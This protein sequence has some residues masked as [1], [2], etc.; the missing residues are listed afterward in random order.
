MSTST[1]TPT[2]FFT[3]LTEPTD[4]ANPS[5]LPSDFDATMAMILAKACGHTYTQ[6]AQ[7]SPLTEAQY[8]NLNTDGTHYTFSCVATFTASEALGPSDLGTPQP[9]PGAG[10][11]DTVPFGF[12]ATASD[13]SLPVFNVLA[14]RGSQTYAEWVNDINALPVSFPFGTKT[15]YV[16]GGFYSQYTTG[17]D[18]T[19]P[20]D[21]NTS[22][23]AGS[24]AA[25]VAALFA[26]GGPLAGSNL[27]LYVTGHSL[28]AA[29]AVFAAFDVV[30]NFA[31]NNVSSVTM[32]HFAPPQVSAGISGTIDN[33]PINLSDL[34]FAQS[35]RAAVKAYAIVNS[36]DIVP[37]LPTSPLT[38]GTLTFSYL[39]AVSQANTISYCAQLGDIS[40]NHSLVDNYLPY[41]ERLVH[42]FRPA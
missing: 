26:A 25:Q 3:A 8:Q 42:G 30:A 32:I 11:F 35:F 38:L 22:R 5:P 21:G 19:P 10:E 13:G 18:G 28:G 39:S 16:H 29:L 14:L 12:V 24:L 36:A 15:C 23:P 9:Q 17:T 1:T 4:L 41:V 7:G 20:G 34:T 31:P 6:Y 2:P 40:S 33:L 37:I 27:P